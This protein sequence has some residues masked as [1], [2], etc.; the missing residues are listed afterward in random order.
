[1]CV[2][3]LERIDEQRL[4]DAKFKA[5]VSSMPAEGSDSSTIVDPFSI[6]PEY[7]AVHDASPNCENN[8]DKI[9][10]EV[11]TIVREVQPFCHPSMMPTFGP[12]GCGPVAVSYINALYVYPIQVDKFQFRNIAIRVQLLSKEIDA[13]IDI[14]SSE[15]QD[16][17]LRAVY[18]PDQRA[19]SGGCTQVNYHQKNPQF[20][21]EIK[22]CLPEKLTREHHILFSFY[23]VHCKK[24]LSHQQQQE[25]VG[26][27][28][29]PILQKDGSLLLDSN[30]VVNVI[31]VTA[32][33]KASHT[34]GRMILPS[35]YMAQARASL[36]D[37]SKTT[38]TCRTRALSSIH[39]QDKSVAAFLQ[40]FHGPAISNGHQ[41]GSWSPGKDEDLIVNRLLGLRNANTV[42]V[43]YFFFSIAKLVLSYLRFGS[44]V[45]RWAAFR[46]F[47]AVLE[48]ASWTPHRSLRVQDMNQ[49]LQ[50]FVQI[51][52]DER[53]IVA[54]S[55]TATPKCSSPS[56]A[57]RKQ[58][59]SVYE[60]VLVEWLAL[61]QDNTP[62]EDVVDTKRISLV[63]TS[64]LLQLILKSIAMNML[65][66][67]GCEAPSLQLPSYLSNGDEAL[68]E[69]VLQELISCV[70]VSS[71]GLLL[72]KEVNRSVAF[73]C[74]GVFLVVTNGVS[75]RVITRYINS[76]DGNQRDA[77]ILVHLLFP[78]LRILIDFE[79]FA[80]VNSSKFGGDKDA[81]S[82]WLARLIFEKLL[83]VV[84]EQVEDKIRSEALRLVRRMFSAQAHNFRYQTLKQQERI[85][86]LYFPMIVNMAQFTSRGKLL[87]S[88]LDDTTEK[89]CE[90]RK[91]LLICVVHLL[92]S[93]S[94]IHLTCFFQQCA[95]QR[96]THIPDASSTPLPGLLSA[97]T[98]LIHRRSVVRRHLRQE[99]QYKNTVKAVSGYDE[100][101]VHACLSLLWHT[102]DIYLVEDSPITWQ[103][104]LC[105]DLSAREGRLSLM[106]LELHLK[107]R[108][109]QHRIG[110][111]DST[112]NATTTSSGNSSPK[113][114]TASATATTSSF[115]SRRTSTQ[116]SLP[117]SWGGK[118]SLTTVQRRGSHSGSQETKLGSTTIGFGSR[119]SIGDEGSTGDFEPQIKQVVRITAVTLLRTLRTAVDRFEPV[120]RSIEMLFDS[121]RDARARQAR[122]S[123][124]AFL[125]EAYTLLGSLTSLVFFLL[126]RSA[127]IE[128]LYQSDEEDEICDEGER[129]KS[130]IADIFQF[131][132]SFLL[133]FQ[134]AIFANRVKDLPL[135]H[136]Q[137]RIKLLLSIA[138][139]AKCT[140]VQQ[141]ATRFLCQLLDVCYNQTGSTELIKR[142]L[143]KV[144]SANFFK[145]SSQG[146]SS[147]HQLLDLP[148]LPS[149]PELSCSALR[150]VLT[151]MMEYS[152]P[153]DGHGSFRIQ[154]VHL[155]HELRAQTNVYEQWFA[156][157][158]D[159]DATA[160][161]DREAIANGLHC[162][163]DSI[164]PYWLLHEK[165]QWMNALLRLQLL[166]RNFAEAACCKLTC[167][168]FTTKASGS[169]DASSSRDELMFWTLQELRLA[170][171]YAAKAS[172]LDQ[173]L[174]IGEQLL[175]LLKR[176]KRFREYQEMLREIDQLL[177]STD[178]LENQ[179]AGEF[180]FYR[181]V[182]V[183]AD[184]FT[185]CEYVYKRSKFTSV[186]EFTSELK[187]VL[188]AT[189]PSCDRVELVPEAKTFPEPNERSNGTLYF[190]VT[191]LEVIKN[192]WMS[193]SAMFQFATPFTLGTG[194]S[195]YGKSSEQLKRVTQL[196]VAK[197]FPCELTRQLVLKRDECVRCPIDT[198]MDDIDK[199]CAMLQSEVDKHRQGQMDLKTLTLL[200]KGSVD[201]HVHGGIPEVM[202]AFLPLDALEYDA[203]SFGLIDASGQPMEQE[204]S[205]RKRQSLA[206]ILIRFLT[207][208]S[209]CLT[210]SGATFRAA[211]D[212]LSP[213]QCEFE[214]SFA[215]LVASARARLAH[216]PL[217]DEALQQQLQAL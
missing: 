81:A 99:D 139:T 129:Y 95:S 112:S 48:K 28:A 46:A 157:T 175:Q 153:N 130:V 7:Q 13:V 68:L 152:C 51:V 59:E 194:S 120:L 128:A 91:E 31:P 15:V 113:A 71:L 94:D 163:M 134:V 215:A 2:F 140:I 89:T 159:A 70:G 131:L 61:L 200:L 75:A 5:S 186:S 92:S 177:S 103:R 84:D 119:K 43:R 53:V 188:L 24:I 21:S 216:V 93:V 88:V 57:S 109:S 192:D 125:E 167:I 56:N 143:F 171:Q 133:R 100:V 47:L 202:E 49:L 170:F 85:A 154:F 164:S 155:V 44:A 212:S 10:P 145:S 150:D 8:H 60:A 206:Q 52:F 34:T 176:L 77:N 35:G 160:A 151:I 209:T 33:A 39:S 135:F 136:D 79:L 165:Q 40:L 25:L 189:N 45:V 101:R 107:H 184:S 80:E 116:R 191:T 141:Y 102:I 97:T 105:P 90:L 58:P 211:D 138:A 180:S 207:L 26:Y 54:P 205:A 214:K 104:M 114:H 158:T 82:P 96:C 142:S 18:G 162:I 55:R 137:K 132:Q 201:T 144:F 6:Y 179:H 20:E 217:P 182:V 65:S 11:K 178:I 115:S 108:R 17:V 29:V 149:A 193:G 98:T 111:V 63:Y 124:P 148:P 118:N 169:T 67:A 66:S 69:Q 3:N 117:R 147:S 41:N 106:D 76:I 16:S 73:F 38:F 122:N 187:T 74:R 127:G 146:T 198:A 185:H 50:Y 183:G 110:I 19:T 172:W 203:A 196:T 37:A 121:S 42:N 72:Q 204:K 83:A 166:L 156:A 14:N 27:A 12:T 30:Y 181:V 173:Q 9:N 123:C 86:L 23:H 168:T 190:R 32:Q 78:F 126:K 199:R 210:I 213:L 4:I 195:S 87:G 62:T 174:A 36:V 22:I 161:Y 1:M 197:A 208:C 64:I